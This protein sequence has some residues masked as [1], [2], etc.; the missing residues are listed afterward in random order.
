MALP[1]HIFVMGKR[2]LVRQHLSI[3]MAFWL[4]HWNEKSISRGD[5]GHMTLLGYY[6][7]IIQQV[8]YTDGLAQDCNNS[9]N[10]VRLQILSIY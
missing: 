7:Y 5:I 8:C 3:K 2:R 4:W 9:N 1:Y 6:I 10:W